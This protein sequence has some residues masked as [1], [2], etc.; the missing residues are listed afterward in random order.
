[1]AAR[2]QGVKGQGTCVPVQGCDEGGDVADGLVDAVA[3]LQ[4]GGLTVQLL[5][6]TVEVR[7]ASQQVL[8]T[9]L[10]ELRV[11]HQ[12]LHQV[13]PARADTLRA[14]AAAAAAAAASPLLD[15]RRVQERLFDPLVEQPL[16]LRRA[17]PVQEAGQGLGPRGAVRG[18][19]GTQ[20]LSGDHLW[21][22]GGGGGLTWKRL[23]ALTAALSSL[24][25]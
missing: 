5:G 22:C 10:P 18:A 12:T 20:E 15:P 7:K 8:L 9:R 1:M 13:Q 16:A 3:V 19:L 21:V 6:K 2:A 23:R 14:G 4:R 24:M 25:Y 11:T 17:A